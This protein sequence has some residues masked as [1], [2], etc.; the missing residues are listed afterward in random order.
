VTSALHAQRR[1]HAPDVRLRRRVVTAD[2]VGGAGAHFQFRPVQRHPNPAVE[3]F[4]GEREVLEP[5]VQT[6]P[7]S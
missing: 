5:E 2:I 7:P 1:D 6:A 4:V 3:A